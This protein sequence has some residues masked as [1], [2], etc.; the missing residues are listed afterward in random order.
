[1]PVPRPVTS[2]GSVPVMTD[3][4]AE[5]GVVFPMP[6]SPVPMISRPSWYFSTSS[7]PARIACSASSRV[8]AGPTA[9]FFV[10][11][12]TFLISRPSAGSKSWSTPTSTTMTRAPQ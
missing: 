10:P 3:T 5:D 9:M 12:A 1:M 6:M 4:M 7:M 8:M 11:W 2:S